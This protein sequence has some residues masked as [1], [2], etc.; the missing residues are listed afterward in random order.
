MR[1]FSDLRIKAFIRPAFDACGTL[2][3]LADLKF[4]FHV[5]GNTLFKLRNVEA[6][7]RFLIHDEHVI[8]KD[9]RLPSPSCGK[10]KASETYRPLLK[11]FRYLVVH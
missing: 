1:A 2:G 10:P 6:S 11:I 5:V 8:E 9:V 3:L 4:S 7:Q